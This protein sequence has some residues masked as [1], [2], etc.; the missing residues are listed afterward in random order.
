V[1]LS[2]LHVEIFFSGESKFMKLGPPLE[3]NGKIV[4]AEGVNIRGEK[5]FE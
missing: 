5:I 4:G 1:G 2:R 3:V